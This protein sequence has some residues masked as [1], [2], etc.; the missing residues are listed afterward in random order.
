MADYLFI[1]EQTK[2]PTDYPARVFAEVLV[3]TV[4]RSAIGSN[5]N[6][7]AASTLKIMVGK[8]IPT[9]AEDR[10]V[11]SARLRE[12]FRRIGYNTDFVS[13]TIKQYLTEYMKS[14]IFSDDWSP[15]KESTQLYVEPWHT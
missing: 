14:L 11:M 1:Y 5:A 4:H 3:K 7:L 13:G 15:E 9:N 8:F 12:Y 2:Q 6:M 10:A